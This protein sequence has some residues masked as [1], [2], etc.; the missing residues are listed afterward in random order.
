[1]AY[2]L[3]KIEDINVYQSIAKFNYDMI[4]QKAVYQDNIK[5]IITLY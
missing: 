3:D 4:K 1:M 2:A 5:K